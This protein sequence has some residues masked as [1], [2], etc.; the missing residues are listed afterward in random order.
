MKITLW[1]THPQAILGVYDFLLSDKYNRS[2]SRLEIM[3]YKVLN[4]DI[5]SYTNA[6]LHFERPL[7]TPEPCGVIFMM[8]GCTLLDFKI[9]SPFHCHDK[10]WKNQDVFLI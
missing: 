3:V 2:S 10:A 7:L 5:L 6:S 8:D 9:S 1:F 4:M